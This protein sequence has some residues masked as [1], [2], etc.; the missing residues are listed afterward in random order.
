MPLPFPYG[1]RLPVQ[2][3]SDPYWKVYCI[4]ERLSKEQKQV[5]YVNGSDGSCSH[6]TNHRATDSACYAPFGVLRLQQ[7]G[8]PARCLMLR[9][10]LTENHRRLR[11]QWCDER[12]TW[13]VEWYDIVFTDESRFGLQHHDGR[14]RVC[15]HRVERLLKCCVMHRHTGLAP[16]I[17]IWGGIEFHYAS[18]CNAILFFTIEL[19]HWPACSPDLSLIQKVW[20]TF[21]QRLTQPLTL[22][23]LWQYVE[24]TWTAIPPRIHPKL[25]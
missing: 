11:R 24:S 17:L 25:L 10:H 4:L 15:R 14:I 13:T 1:Y 12:R 5:D 9:L 19:L 16:G 21:A 22:D 18:C 23:Q 3:T 2:D 20:L 6:I 7:S 8:M